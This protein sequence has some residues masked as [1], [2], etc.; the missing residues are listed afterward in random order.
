MRRRHKVMGWI[1]IDVGS[2]FDCAYIEQILYFTAA[3][4]CGI[5]LSLTSLVLW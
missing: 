3:P 2:S 1:V 4:G 5:A